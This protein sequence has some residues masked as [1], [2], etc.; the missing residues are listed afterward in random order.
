VSAAVGI[1]LVL[2]VATA[3]TAIVGF[4]LKHRGAVESPDVELRRPVSTSI[5]LFRSRWYILGILVALGSWGL[6][7]G[8]LSL[9]PISL[10][11]SV[12]AG[13]LVLLTVLA[14]RVFGLPVSRREWVGVACA[15]AG[16]AVLAATL[17]G[18]GDSA[19]NDYDTR[20]LALYVGIAS[21]LAVAAAVTA[22]AGPGR[23]PLLGASAGLFWGASDVSIKALS[24]EEGVAQAILHPL[25]L[26]VVVA[27]L[28]GFAIS[29]RSL[30]I[31]PPVAVIA[32]TSTAANACTI[33]AG[34]VLFGDPLPDDAAGLV[35]RVLAFAL[36]IVAA[37]MTPPPALVEDAEAGHTG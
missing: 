27:S 1:G 4:L 32:I 34:P 33:L 7:V 31:G 26:V 23:G 15:A 18:G 37:A 19:H 30:Q 6:H 5:A 13:G 35:L 16:L 8:A 22:G 20:R 28:V 11:Q 10:V 21:A 25:A 36:V 2:A 29:A 3:L 14:D 24:A 12:I 9:A 17:E